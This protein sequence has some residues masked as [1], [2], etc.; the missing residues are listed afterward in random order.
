MRD[1]IGL[2][3]CSTFKLYFLRPRIELINA[4][5]IMCAIKTSVV[6]M[7]IECLYVED[8]TQSKRTFPFPKISSSTYKQGSK[9]CVEFVIQGVTRS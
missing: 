3:R 9:Q 2:L 7:N 4:P 8:A 1:N 5:T 6:S